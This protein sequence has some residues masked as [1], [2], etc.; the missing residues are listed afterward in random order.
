MNKLS[1]LILGG[2]LAL[3]AILPAQ[4]QTRRERLHDHVYYL[5]AD[6]LRGRKACSPDATKAAEYII[7]EYE[8]AGLKPLFRE[9]WYDRFTRKGDHES[10]FKNV[11]GLIEGTDP[12]LRGECIVIGAHYDHLGVRQ[13]KIYNGA[14]DNASGSAAVI[15]IARA[16]AGAQPRRSIIIAAFDAEEIGLVGSSHLAERLD[17][18]GFHIKLMMSVDMVGWLKAGKALKLEGVA[19]RMPDRPKVP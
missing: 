7:G 11:V 16:L 15:E 17:T 8:Q 18:L 9:G 5:A 4:A 10:D 14:D 1:T 13:D 2:G 6:S 3:L 12:A 19:S